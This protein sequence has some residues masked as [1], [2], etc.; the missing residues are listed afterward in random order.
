MKGGEELGIWKRLKS[1]GRNGSG[2]DTVTV[3]QIV[4]LLNRGA[5]LI[6]FGRQLYDIPEVRLAIN[7]IA[8][9]VGSVPFYHARADTD[10]NIVQQNSKVQ[11]VLGIRTNQY[12]GPQIFWT[13]A[14]T[15]LLLSNN[16]YIFP[17]WDD[18]GNLRGLY[19]LPFTSHEFF[20]AP[21][22]QIGIR[23]PAAGGGYDFYYS[24][25][26]HL[27]R[28]PTQNGGAR[29]QA[30]SGYVEITNTLQD[31]AVKDSKNSQ[32]I[33]A[34]L[35]NK[36]QLKGTDQVKKLEEF[37]QNY[38]TAE[39]T[40]G[41]GMIGPEYEVKDLNLK[42]TPLNKDV[43]EA[44]VDYLFTYFGGSRKIFTH[45]ASE[46]E[47]SQFIV[48]TILPIIYQIEEELTFKLF[49]TNELG[50]GNKVLSELAD[51]EIST[52]AARTAFYKEMLFGGVMNRNEVR[53]RI[54]LP[55]GPS[56]LDKFMESKNFQTLPPGDYTVKGGE[57]NSGTE[58][59]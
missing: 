8:E 49:S 5:P 46:I 3:T 25:I 40:T 31:Q 41:F 29:K 14:V 42:T 18:S 15:R 36:T 17:D 52:M 37:K 57:T 45:T 16:V 33:A 35:I 32:R 20:D 22:G 23:F 30:T 28:F 50:H 13:Y 12:Q 19:V 55:R 24:D 1:I 51:L 54:G 48:N 2:S 56:E 7:F 47:V 4:D 58:S 38:L 26:V 10:G 53:R 21:D 44:I 6:G 34:L 27:Q 11:H 43:L 39:N 59:E 9:K